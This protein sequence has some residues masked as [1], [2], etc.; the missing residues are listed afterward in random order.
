MKLREGLF[1]VDIQ[2]PSLGLKLLERAVNRDTDFISEFAMM[3]DTDFISGFAMMRA[4][5]TVDLM[6]LLPQLHDHMKEPVLSKFP[7]YEIRSDG[8]KAFGGLKDV[9]H[10]TSNWGPR[11]QLLESVTM[12][13]GNATVRF[14]HLV[15][16]PGSAMLLDVAAAENVRWDKYKMR[17]N[18]RMSLVSER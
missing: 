14:P 18:I 6:S 13:N 9:L 7:E 17:R 1:P 8:K 10:V 3:R 16:Q 4:A 5:Y 11:E 15:E 2:R 12:P